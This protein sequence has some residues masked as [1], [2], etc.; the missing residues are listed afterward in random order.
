MILETLETIFY[1][2]LQ[3]GYNVLDN[4]MYVRTYIQRKQLFPW[5]FKYW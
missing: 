4:N 2:Y 5:E 1:E 3:S